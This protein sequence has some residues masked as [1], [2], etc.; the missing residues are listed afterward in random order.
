MTR[1]EPAPSSRIAAARAE[2]L[3]RELAI[4]RDVGAPAPV[5][6]VVERGVGVVL[7]RARVDEVVD[8]A[9][10]GEPAHR[11]S[12]RALRRAAAGHRAGAGGACAGGSDRRR[13]RRRRG[14][15]RCAI[16]AR[17][18]SASLPAA[19]SSSANSSTAS[20]ISSRPPA[21]SAW[22]PLL[23]RR[24]ELALRDQDVAQPLAVAA[25]DVELHDQ[26][27]RELVDRARAA[28]RRAARR[29]GTARAATPNA[30][31]FD[32]SRPS[33]TARVELRRAP[34]TRARGAWRARRRRARTTAGPCAA[35][36]GARG[37]LVGP[38]AVPLALLVVELLGLG[39]LGLGLAV[40]RAAS[41]APP[42]DRRDRARPDPRRRTRRAA[43]VGRGAVSAT[44]G[45]VVGAPGPSSR[46]ARYGDS[47]AST[48][49]STI[50]S[51]ERRAA[52]P[53][54]RRWISS[55][56][57][58]G[59]H[60]LISLRQRSSARQV[61]GSKPKSSRA[62]NL[63]ARSMR[64]GSS[65]NRMSGSPIVRIELGVEVGEAADVV[66]D[67]LALDVVEQAVDR[68]VAA[69]RV[70]GLGAEHVV[71]AD[72]EVVVVLVAR[73]G[74]ER[75]GLD[76]LRA[77]EH[78]GEP[79]PAADDPRVAERRLDLVRRRARRD[80]EVLRRAADEQV[81]HAA[82]DEV[83]LVAGAGQLADHAIGIGVD[84]GAVQRRHRN[85][86][87]VPRA[88][89]A[90]QVCE[91]IDVPVTRALTRS[92]PERYLMRPR[93]TIDPDVPRRSL[94]TSRSPTSIALPVA[95]G[96]VRARR[97]GRRGQ[98]GAARAA[99]A[100]ADAGRRRKVWDCA[101]GARA[102]CGAIA[103]SR[104]RSCSAARSR[105]RR[106]RSASD[107]PSHVGRAARARRAGAC[108]ARAR[109]L[110]ARPRARAPSAA[111]PRAAAREPRPGRR[112]HRARAST[113]SSS[114]C[115]PRRARC[116]R[117]TALD[118][119]RRARRSRRIETAA[120]ADGA[121][122]PPAARVRRPRP[123][124]HRCCV[125]PDALLD[126][127]ARAARAAACRPSAEL[128][129]ATGAGAVAIEADRGLLRQV[130]RNLV[131]NASEA[132][133]PRAAI[134]RRL[135]HRASTDGTPWWELEVTRQRRRHGRARRSARIFDPF[136]STK[137]EHHGL[138]LSAVLGIVR[139]L[140]GE[141]DVDSRARPRLDVPRAP[142][143]RRRARRHRGGARRASSRAL[144]S[145]P[146]LRVLVA[147]DE[148]TVR[149][150]VRRLLERRGAIVVLASDGARG[151]AAAPT[152]SVRRSCSST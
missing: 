115:S 151:R 66:D 83:R 123:V 131:E 14:L 130:I 109:A 62:A 70:L 126:E 132:L 11:R 31:A 56:R 121:A 57:R 98:R 85:E 54:S 87:A 114:A 95:G 81:A 138:G 84:R 72:Q 150:T 28:R 13:R 77:E 22:A 100:R 152:Q 88:P 103:R 51:N 120:E 133:P 86:R 12:R 92:T 52:P 1:P 7:A 18:A 42:R 147:D 143:D 24:R 23:A 58:G 60:L 148:P 41:P 108:V 79:E 104:G 5:L 76:D 29:A 125:D 45:A 136:F 89:N 6:V 142:A 69:P 128:D 122:D 44:G 33:P 4:E 127:S 73:V 19:R 48:P 80:V 124:R 39:R 38:H 53:R 105:S 116:A 137:P 119:R 63:I 75:R 36:G 102:R 97:H 46:P 35:C 149:S 144:E 113:T 21:S 141:L 139:R 135:P 129:V 10:R 17:A 78:V 74:A 25:R 20:S 145:S 32:G 64:T 140:G 67:L 107:G 26:R 3:A 112:R 65:W 30:T 49:V 94:M 59:A 47:T 15:R 110:D 101:P 91:P 37:R 106:R 134:E 2:P 90:A 34:P 146:A 93:S 68:E 117:T 82:A 118:R 111:T 55:S 16:A 71:A 8:Q 27:V 96:G 9:R 99:R 50:S 40:D 61:A 43:T